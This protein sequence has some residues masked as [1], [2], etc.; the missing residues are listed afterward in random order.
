MITYLWQDGELGAELVEAEPGDVDAVDADLPPSSLDDPEQS[1]GEGG[2]TR[3][4]A[5]NNTNL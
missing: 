1:Q 3:S 2:L 4:G 5:T